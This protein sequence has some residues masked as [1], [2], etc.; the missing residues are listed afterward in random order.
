MLLASGTEIYNP[1]KDSC[2]HILYF[3]QKEKNNNNNDNNKPRLYREGRILLPSLRTSLE[4][5]CT[6]RVG[7]LLEVPGVWSDTENL[8]PGQEVSDST[9]CLLTALRAHLINKTFLGRQFLPGCRRVTFP[10]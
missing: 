3:S 8:M 4:W 6:K 5:S 7:E 10:V 1:R 2:K 9:P